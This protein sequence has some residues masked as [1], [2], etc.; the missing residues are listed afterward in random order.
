MTTMD[1]VRILEIARQFRTAIESIPPEARPIGMQCFPRGAC[2]DAA[3]LFGALLVDRSIPGFEYI[4]GERGSKSDNTWVSHAWLQRNDLVVDL[5]ADQF[6][7]APADV[8]VASPSTWHMQ[9]ST[10]P[11]QESDFRKWSGYGAE[12]LYPMYARVIGA[13]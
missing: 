7:D 12:L 4:C 2:G 8:I 1:T 5:T 13:L 9:F 11:G 6:S 10:A 3:L